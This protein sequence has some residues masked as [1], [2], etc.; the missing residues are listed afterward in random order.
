MLRFWAVFWDFMEYSTI[1]PGG[2]YPTYIIDVEVPPE[3]RPSVPHSP[4]FTAHGKPRRRRDAGLVSGERKIDAS[5]RQREWCAWGTVICVG[6]CEYYSILLIPPPLFSCRLGPR[7]QINLTYVT[8]SRSSSKE[9]S[10]G[11]YLAQSRRKE[12]YARD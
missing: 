6:F 7:T 1:K 8:Q 10:H 11:D 12:A 5:R 2:G 9:G 4:K 3:D